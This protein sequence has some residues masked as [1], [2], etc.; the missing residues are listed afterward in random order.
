MNWMILLVSLVL[1]AAVLA[2]LVMVGFVIYRNRKA[3]RA[4][5]EV[6]QTEADEIASTWHLLNH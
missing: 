5:K 1:L 3:A 6:S 2:A 4:P